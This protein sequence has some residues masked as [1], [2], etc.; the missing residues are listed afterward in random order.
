[1]NVRVFSRIVKAVFP[2][3][4]DFGSLVRGKMFSFKASNDFDPV[5]FE[6]LRLLSEAL[7]TTL[8]NIRGED[9]SYCD[10]CGPDLVCIVTVEFGG[11]G[12]SV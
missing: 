12:D 2:G 8:I 7:G 3:A 6:K 5:T 11:E 10:T 1:M 4:Y 9:D